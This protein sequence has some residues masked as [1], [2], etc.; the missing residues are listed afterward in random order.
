M[1]TSNYGS[2]F[3]CNYNANSLDEWGFTSDKITGLQAN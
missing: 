1:N 2:N 3:G